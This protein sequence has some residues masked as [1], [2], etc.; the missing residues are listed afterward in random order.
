MF[1]ERSSTELNTQHKAYDLCVITAANEYQAQ[2][3]EEQLEWRRNMNSLPEETEFLV[4]S[5]PQGKRIGSG[6]STLYVLCR[7]LERFISSG[8]VG[9]SQSLH[10]LFKEKRILILHSGG[11]SRRLPSYSAVGKIFLPLPT[12]DP[13]GDVGMGGFVTLFD[14]FSTI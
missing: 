4:I 5:D 10:Q 6:G 14:I 7:L 8:E 11:D 1:N 3:Y 2:G 9:S 12:S 13:C